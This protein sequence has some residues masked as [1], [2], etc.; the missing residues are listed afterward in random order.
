MVFKWNEYNV[1]HTSTKTLQEKTNDLFLRIKKQN[2]EMLKQNIN[3][4][5]AT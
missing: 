2:K 3:K 1:N 5:P 4:I